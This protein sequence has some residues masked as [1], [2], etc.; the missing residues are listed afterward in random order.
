MSRFT[1]ICFCLFT[2]FTSSAQDTWRG[3]IVEPENRCSPYDKKKQYP[4]PQSVEDAI[5]VQMGGH[6]YGPYT[7]RYFASD[8]ETDIEHIVAA[9]EGHDSG[10]CSASAETREQF[11]TDMLNLTLAAPKVNRCSSTGKCGLDA[12]E[13]MPTKNKCWFANRI[14]EIKVKYSLSANQ[15]EADA[16]KSVLASCESVEMIFFPKADQSIVDLPTPSSQGALNM[17]DD[18]KNGRITCSEARAH[19]IA[20]VRRGH[21]AYIFM[22]DR[23][24]NGVVCE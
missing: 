8:K 10:L 14:V 20:P 7:G 2:I 4:Y 22:N 13:W 6:V 1:I 19:G 18:N 9:S 23:D 15:A 21:A 3:L 17:F 16:L 11:A 5:V 24:N 12:A